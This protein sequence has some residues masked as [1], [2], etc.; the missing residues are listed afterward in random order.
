MDHITL[1]SELYK[2]YRENDWEYAKQLQ[3]AYPDMAEETMRILIN[4]ENSQDAWQQL[5]EK[6]K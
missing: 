4:A 2:A 1:L 6:D 3:I 5:E